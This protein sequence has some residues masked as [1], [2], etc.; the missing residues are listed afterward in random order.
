MGWRTL[1]V[2]IPVVAGLVLIALGAMCYQ[3]MTDARAIRKLLLDRLAERFVGA[4]VRVESAQL[5][6][7]G[8]IFFTELRMARRNALDN[9]DFLYIPSGIVYHDKE[10]LLDGC[11]G[12]RK[13]ELTR[14]VVRIVRERD[15]T[16]NC[17]GLLAPAPPEQPLPTLVL[18]AATLQFEDRTVAPGQ[19]LL[20]V[21]GLEI[22][23]VNDPQPVVTIEGRG[24]TDLFGPVRF[25]ATADRTAGA[26]HLTLSMDA[27]PLGGDLL[28]RAALLLPG[29]AGEVRELG[30]VAVLDLDLKFAPRVSPTPTF[31]VRGRIERGTLAHTALPLP[32]HQIAASFKAS[33]RV[34]PGALWPRSPL[35]IYLPEIHVTAKYGSASVTATAAG[36]AVPNTFTDLTT[37]AVVATLDGKATSVDL[38]EALLRA[39]PQHLSNL[40]PAFQPRGPISVALSFR[41]LGAGAWHSHWTFDLEGI[42]ARFHELPYPVRTITGRIVRVNTHAN[43]PVIT[44]DVTGKASDQDVRLTGTLTGPAGNGVDLRLVGDNLPIDDLVFAALPAKPRALAQQF[45][46]RGR[47]ALDATIRRTQGSP[48]FHN[49]YRLWLR[50][51]TVSYDLFPYKLTNATGELDVTTNAGAIRWEARDLRGRHGT[52]EIS[53][54]ARS[55]PAG[56]R[57]D[58]WPGS[59]LRTPAHPSSA[60]APVR[61]VAAI[62]VRLRGTNVRVD[63]E[64]EAALAPPGMATRRQLHQTWATMNPSGAI[65][66]AVE[67]LDLPDLPNALAVSVA[68]GGCRLQPRFF[69]VP[70]ERVEGVCHYG[71][72][73]VELRDLQAHHGTG[74]VQVPAGVV[75]LKPSGG[76]QVRLGQG[77]L[78]VWNLTASREFVQALPVALRRTL[79][80]IQFRGKFNLST[81]LVLETGAGTAPPSVW[82]DG[83]LGLR[84]GAVNFGVELSGITGQFS[85]SGQ[86]N[87]QR[88]E[89]ASGNVLLEEA[90]IL[91]QPLQ[92]LQAAFEFPRAHPE[93]LQLRNL[94]ASLFGGI[95]AGEGHIAFAP[96]L[97]YDLMFKALKIDLEKFGGHNFP[98]TGAELQGAVT[99]ALHLVG[100]G[101]ALSDLRGNGRIEIPNGKLYR[102]PWTLDLLKTINLQIPDRTAFEKAR[103]TFAIE[104]ARM[105]VEE[106]ELTGN[107]I[108]LRGNGALNLDGTNLALDFSTDL[109]GKTLPPGLAE[110]PRWFSDQLFQIKVRGKLGQVRYERELMPRMLGPLK[111][112]MTGN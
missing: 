60:L 49:R 79:E 83:G 41:R 12:I 35:G 37:D 111:Q 1:L 80:A 52:A 8:G 17:E 86:H 57:L 110:L 55:V 70:L 69:E 112:A 19:V 88:L 53:G 98:E 92:N 58:T 3:F 62:Q 81:A 42:A 100:D 50:D 23:V 75:Y 95:L 101:T 22:T 6:P 94:K 63:G 102:L 40:E 20:A 78:Q 96:T 56:E 85:C 73:R 105:V 74:R 103:A 65:N 89:T 54:E 7:L 46:P 4:N 27:I 31:E 43:N 76:Y 33:N 109:W 51:G 26:L 28:R 61:S 5:R 99:A 30:G 107:A 13:V 68:V 16:L 104:G 45:Q 66:F 87:G 14:P 21:R 25:K 32:L 48:H 39:L 38:T 11:L 72:G 34:T 71:Q 2:R 93:K 90:T 77:Q 10:R 9:G 108:N 67:A 91:K 84:D 36:I 18:R 106:L 82:W 44:V 29:L 97:H 59:K 47:F 24:A 15:G 64:L